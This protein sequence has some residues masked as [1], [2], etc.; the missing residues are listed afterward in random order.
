ML[1]LANGSSYNMLFLLEKSCH[2]ASLC[3]YCVTWNTAAL[4]LP[5]LGVT[6]EELVNVLDCAKILH[7]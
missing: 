2:S 5:I 7:H 6:P 4:R 3:L 1:P